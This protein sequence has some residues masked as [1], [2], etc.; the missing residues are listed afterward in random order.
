M[1][2]E[3]FRALEAKTRRR[4]RKGPEQEL[5]EG[6]VVCIREILPEEVKFTASAAGVPLTPKVR[7][8]L[9]A[10]GLEP[11]WPDL[12]FL[13]PDGV[14][15]YIE[16]KTPQG[17]LSRPQREFRDACQGH[18]IWAL[19]RTWADI[20]NALAHWCWLNGLAL[21]PLHPLTRAR[22]AR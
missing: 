10:A 20:E 19:A 11:G 2:V 5:Q 13:F 15:R 9:K 14:T 22:F 17:S 18:D 8:D 7:S 16:D 12:Q 3:E 4:R 21:K 1:K 6:W